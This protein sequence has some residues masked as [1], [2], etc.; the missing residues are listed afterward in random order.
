MASTTVMTKQTKTA[1][2]K[3]FRGFLPVVIDVETGGLN[4]NTDA[5]L[6]IA[7]S[8]I[9]MDEDGKIHPG[10][11][12]HAHVEPFVG[13]NLDPESLKLNRI[14]PNHPFRMAVAE[15]VALEDLFAAIKVKLKEYR[16]ERA[17]LVGH[18][19]WFDLFFLKAAAARCKFKKIPL[20]AFTS[21]DTASLS[22]LIFG[23]T[24]LIKACHRAGIEFDIKEAHSAIYDC[25]KTADLFCKIVN[26]YQSVF[27]GQQI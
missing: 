19:S 12:I 8:I 5:L 17:V 13:A 4:S 1:M 23:Q 14:D 25:Q 22:A 16:C 10:E 3:R 20:H 9:Y 6:E 27:Q 7:S 26:D 21:L 24:V 2:A 18:N 11:I 15:Q